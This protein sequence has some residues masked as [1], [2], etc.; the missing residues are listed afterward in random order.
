VSNL[1]ALREELKAH[2]NT[3]G[4]VDWGCILKTATR[5]KRIADESIRQRALDEL[6]NPEKQEIE[7]LE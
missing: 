4:D 6:L 5:A 1:N 2:L 7:V 3:S